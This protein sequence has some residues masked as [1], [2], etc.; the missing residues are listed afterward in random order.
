MAIDEALLIEAL[1]EEEEMDVGFI[2]LGAMGSAMARR[3]IELG[4]HVRVWNRSPEPI[5]N[6]V[7]MGGHRADT[8]QEAL[9][10]QAAITMLANDDAVRGVL[11]ESGA[12]QASAR[13]LI[14]VMTATIS[15]DLAKLL[16][17]VHADCGLAYVAAPVLGRPDV[18][19]LGGLHV[20]VAGNASAIACVQPLLDALGK[21][22]WHISDQP[23][24]ANVAKIAANLLLAS[25]IEAMAEVITLAERHQLD[26]ARM[27][28]ALTGSLFS[29]PVYRTYG[30]IILNRAF[31]PA[32]FKA[33]LGLKDVNL[34][35]SAGESAG[36]A[37]PIAGL[38]H[39]S[40]LD[41]IAH[42]H[43]NSDWAALATASARRAGLDRGN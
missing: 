24:Q 7:R 39:D 25:A 38:V 35:V 12:L 17:K 29:A 9:S 20:L 43:G 6:I 37:L 1:A 34:A 30:D 26:A 13:G 40:L 42:G 19:A 33:S 18:A 14:H 5:D 8:P 32:L 22:T 31:E 28:T 27:M 36:V 41:A 15:V 23:H 3:L 11:L 4:H 16:E 10:A 21:K 2:G